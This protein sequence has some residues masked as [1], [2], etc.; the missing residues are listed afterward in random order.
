MYALPVMSVRPSYPAVPSS[1]WIAFSTREPEWDEFPIEVGGNSTSWK[2]RIVFRSYTEM[3]AN[4]LWIY[5]RRVEQPELPVNLRQIQKAKDLTAYVS[6]R[7][8][9]YDVVGR[10]LWGEAIKYDRLS[11]FAPP[12]RKL[13]ESVDGIGFPPDVLEAIS[14]LKQ[15]IKPQ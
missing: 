8:I 13:L 4:P 11:V 14:Q 3:G 6:L 2:N 10:E 12:L 15:L 7:D 9:K 5:W 1:P